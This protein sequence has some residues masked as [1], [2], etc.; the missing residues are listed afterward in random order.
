MTFRALSVIDDNVWL[1]GISGQPWFSVVHADTNVIN[2]D[3]RLPLAQ[4]SPARGEGGLHPLPNE[5]ED[6]GEG[7][8]VAGRGLG[9][10]SIALSKPH[11]SE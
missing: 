4:P 2:C 6:R 5:G 8:L 10:I 11:F 7:G 9:M 1:L 3:T